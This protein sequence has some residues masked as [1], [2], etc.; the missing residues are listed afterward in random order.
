M[1]F[2]IIVALGLILVGSVLTMNKLQAD[3]T[4]DPALSPSLNDCWHNDL[5]GGGNILNRSYIGIADLA[6]E[7]CSDKYKNSPEFQ[8]THMTGLAKRKNGTTFYAHS[9]T[10]HPAG[11]KPDD[12]HCQIESVWLD[13]NGGN[14]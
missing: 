12:I 13:N 2:K 3:F 10:N 1:K 5:D 9:F 7:T 14:W 6:Y 11:E 8:N 4:G